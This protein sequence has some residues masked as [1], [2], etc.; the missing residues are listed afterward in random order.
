[1]TSR[2]RDGLG[3]ALGDGALSR[4]GRGRRGQGALRHGVAAPD[5]QH[6]DGDVHEQVLVRKG[7]HRERLALQYLVHAR[8]DRVEQRLERAVEGVPRVIA[9]RHATNGRLGQTEPAAHLRTGHAD[10]VAGALLEAQVVMGEDRLDALQVPGDART[11]DEQHLGKGIERDPVV[12]QKQVVQEIGAT[13]VGRGG[14]IVLGERAQALTPRLECGM[15][16]DVEHVTA[17]AAREMNARDAVERFV[18]AVDAVA[19]RARAHTQPS[20]E[21]G[22]GYSALKQDPLDDVRIV[23]GHVVLPSLNTV[24][25][26]PHGLHPNHRRANGGKTERNRLERGHSLPFRP[27]RPGPRMP[28]FKFKQEY[29]G[30]LASLRV[31]A[32]GKSFSSAVLITSQRAIPSPSRKTHSI[33]T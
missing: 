27:C 21:I 9:V 20:R 12:A 22:G 6:G 33:L 28:L 25:E 5:P 29:C 19:Q 13:A 23:D 17:T 16:G 11:G 8:R 2:S 31:E 30:L 10:P 3:D 18:D 15:V 7:V 14:R 26:N 1:M 4:A 32:K 24:W